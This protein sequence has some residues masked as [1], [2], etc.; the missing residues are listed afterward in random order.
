MAES[1]LDR[2]RRSSHLAGAN[3]AYIEAMYET[4]L[5]GGEDLPP[6]WQRYFGELP[7]VSDD[8]AAATVEVPH[9]GI[10][11]HFERIGRNRLKARPE[12]QSAAVE[13]EHERKQMRVERYHEQTIPKNAETAVDRR[14]SAVGEVVRQVALIGPERP[15]RAGVERPC[16]IVR[17]RHVEHAVVQERRRLEASTARQ[18][19]GL[20]SPRRRQAIHVFAVDL[21]ERAM[22]ASAVVAGKGQPAR[23]T[24]ETAQNV[25]V[26][27]AG[28]GLGVRTIVLR[29]KRAGQHR[30]QHTPGRDREKTSHRHNDYSS[31]I[32]EPSAR[33][34]P[35]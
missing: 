33:S 25:F 24:V 11:Q 5:A 8:P 35:R 14:A 30:H 10:V 15:A 6:E 23:R 17:A 4:Y 29:P 12:K 1:E 19:A 27:H 9:S 34:V 18:R 21:R 28:M 13:S 26:S 7:P 20:E 22:A 32:S 31:A 3:A 16:E 2:M